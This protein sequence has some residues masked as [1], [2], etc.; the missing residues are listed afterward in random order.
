MSAVA[1]VTVECGNDMRLD[2]E[3]ELVISIELVI[4]LTIL[5]QT[6]DYARSLPCLIVKRIVS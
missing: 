5:M 2:D 6:C 4:S 3:P 1:L